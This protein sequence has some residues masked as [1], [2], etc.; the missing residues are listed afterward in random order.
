MIYDDLKPEGIDALD[1]KQPHREIDIFVRDKA[2]ELKDKSKTV[3]II[4]PNIHGI[5]SGPVNQITQQI[6]A[7]IR[8]AI[9]NRF[10]SL[11]VLEI[12]IYLTIY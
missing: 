11:K 9:K 3:I 1:I 8:F 12:Q 7:L 4:P 2:R 5:G 6:P 10:V